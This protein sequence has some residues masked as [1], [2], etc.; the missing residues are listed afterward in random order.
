MHTDDVSTV[1][2]GKQIHIS[3]GAKAIVLNAA[4]TGKHFA[5][6]GTFSAGCPRDTA[7]D[8][9]LDKGDKIANTDDTP[10]YVSS[11]FALYPMNHPA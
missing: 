5:L 3:N 2:R 7:G 4:K 10:Q 1:I 6:S 8:V 11:Q 9:Y